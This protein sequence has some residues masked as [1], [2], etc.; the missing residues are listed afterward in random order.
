MPRPYSVDLRERVL[1]AY[2]AGAGSQRVLATRFSIGVGTVCGWMVAA[3]DKGRRGSRPH[4][5]DRPALGGA[6]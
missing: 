4:G 6:D 5:G 2:E 3:R 1:R